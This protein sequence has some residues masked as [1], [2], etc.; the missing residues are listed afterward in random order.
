MK[1]HRGVNTKVFLRNYEKFS[2]AGAK[3]QFS[4]VPRSVWLF[5]TPWT[6]ARQASLSIT[7]CRLARTQV[8]RV[9]DA[10]QPSHPLLS[11]SPPAFNLSQHQGLFQWVS[12]SNQ[13]AKVLELHLQHQSFQWIFR[14]ISFRTDW[15]DLLAVQGTLK[16]LLQITIQKHPFFSTQSSLRSN[17]H[18]H[19]WLLEKPW[20]WSWRPLLAK[21]CLCFLICCLGLS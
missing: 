7:N 13:V 1:S 8:D 6:A 17:S 12:S 18:I 9:G 3:S 14:L 15:F 20:L 21:R 2:I 10:I 19:T 11:P 4:S 5:A 16:S